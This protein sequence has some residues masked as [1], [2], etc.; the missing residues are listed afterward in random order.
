MD[1]DGLWYEC[2]DLDTNTSI[3]Q[4][5]CEEECARYLKPISVAIWFGFAI[6]S[7][8]SFNSFSSSLLIFIYLV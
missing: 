2:D 6:D 8:N 3:E 4:C 1:F 7:F 5:E